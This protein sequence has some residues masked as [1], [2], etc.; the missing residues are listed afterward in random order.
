[1]QPGLRNWTW[2]S[3]PRGAKGPPRRRAGGL[4]GEFSLARA[5]SMTDT[6]Q[7][8]EAPI[9]SR[10]G[11]VENLGGDPQALTA[12]EETERLWAEVLGMANDE[13]RE[14]LTSVNGFRR[15]LGRSRVPE[16]LTVS[17]PVLPHHRQPVGPP[18]DPT[19]GLW[20]LAKIIARAHAR[21]EAGMSNAAS[22]SPHPESNRVPE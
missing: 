9:R 8:E 2:A 14:P 16:G 6:V 11:E 1:M 19:G 4:P 7:A 21:R 22:P 3:V 5:V 18:K 10:E 17:P 12:L 20:V 13:L 15:H